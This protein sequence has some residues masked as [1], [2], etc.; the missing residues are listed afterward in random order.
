MIK[1]EDTGKLGFGLMRL[2]RKLLAI[3]I[4]QTS[5]MVDAFL[6]AGFTYF[7]TAHVYIG[8]EEAARKALVERHPREKYTLATKLCAPVA[9][10]EKMA[11]DQFYTSL[12]QTGAE[13]FDYY[14]L[15]TLMQ[16]NFEKYEKFHLWDFVN[17]QKEK[18]L[19]K[20]VGFSF[21][22]GPELLERILKEHPEVEFVQL[23]INYADWEN[24]AI[25]SRANYEVAR[26]YGKPVVIM[27]PVKGGKLADPP[28][29]IT[30][31]FRMHSPDRSPASWAIRFAASLDGV[32]TVLSGMSNT[33]QMEDNLSYMRDFKPLDEEEQKIIQKAQKILG[34]SKTIPCTACKY[35]VEGC[36]KQIPIPEVFT[37]MN[38]HI[39]NGQT[40]EA[41]QDYDRI[42]SRGH[43]AADCIACGKCESICPQHIPII[44]ELKKC[45]E[46]LNFSIDNR[47]Q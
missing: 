41:R 37:A 10:T 1:M 4:R 18:G 27:E 29:E 13:Y 12:K 22:D 46:T 7:D 19:I 8:S 40:D 24:P 17:E 34:Y 20:H 44:K 30:E 31:M 14:L 32:L 28:V 15:H 39:G 36:P 23:Q 45:D 16:N 2:P 25:A 38:K 47:G 3:D 6:D 42:K 33:E 26:K 5:E 21:H 11:K 35:C 43:S 9:I